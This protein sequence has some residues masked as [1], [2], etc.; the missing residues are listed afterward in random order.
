[1]KYK[2]SNLFSNLVKCLNAKVDFDQVTT[3]KD[4]KKASSTPKA[5]GTFSQ[6]KPAQASRPSMKASAGKKRA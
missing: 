2:D 1:M 5:K 3:F 6:A 4:H